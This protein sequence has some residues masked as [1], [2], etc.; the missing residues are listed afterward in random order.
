[1]HDATMARLD[2]TWKPWSVARVTKRSACSLTA[3]A[4]LIEKWIAWRRPT[5]FQ[6]CLAIHIL[7]ATYPANDATP[8]GD[9]A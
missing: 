7:N 8:A 5:P 6:R 1:M 9:A 2:L 3:R 4:N